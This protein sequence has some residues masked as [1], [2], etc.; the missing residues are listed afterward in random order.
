MVKSV[1]PSRSAASTNRPGYLT[2]KYLPLPPRIG[3]AWIWPAEYPIG[4]PKLVN[5]RFPT[6][7]MSSPPSRMKVPLTPSW[8]S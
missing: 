2:V 7:Y 6:S 1:T 8:K 4:P 5:R 3:A